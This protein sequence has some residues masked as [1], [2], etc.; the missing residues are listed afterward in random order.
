MRVAPELRR[1]IE[2]RHLNFMDSEYGVAEKVD[3]IFCRNVII[4]FERPTQEAILSKLVQCLTP[5]GHL[6]VGHAE[7]LHNMNLPLT[8]VAPSLYRR[9]GDAA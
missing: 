5:G 1:A 4:Y 8:P 9:V 2:F 6:F 7:T 3:A